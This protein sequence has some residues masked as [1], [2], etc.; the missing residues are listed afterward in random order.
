VST[1]ISLYAGPGSGKSTSAAFIYAI[2]K[3]KGVN[4][5]LVREYVKDWAWEKRE[6]KTFDQFYFLGKQIRR[7]S[8]LM[9]HVDVAV[10]DSPVWLCGYYAEKYT[11]P[12]VRQGVHSAVMGYYEQARIEGH[13]HVH[14]WVKRTKDYNTKGR[15]ESEEEARKIDVEMRTFL[16]AHGVELTEIDT[17]FESLK[18]VVADLF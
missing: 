13:K 2:L 3:Q 8:M 16:T 10:T 1:I 12:L 18:N 14:L 7:E 4:A 5:E 17:D 11:R 15:Y 9:N 6:I